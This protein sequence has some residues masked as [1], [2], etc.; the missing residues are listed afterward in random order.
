MLV[1]DRIPDDD[2]HWLCFLDLMKIDDHLFCPQVTMDDAEH[3]SILIVG[4]HKEFRELYPGKSIIP[5]M[6]FIIHMPR[7]MVE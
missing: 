4:R 3:V 2:E 6:H 1:A 5:K 7:L